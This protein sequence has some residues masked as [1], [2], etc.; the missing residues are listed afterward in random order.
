MNPKI[1]ALTTATEQSQKDY[2]QLQTSISSLSDEKVGKD[3]FDLEV[4]KL[5]KNYQ[6]RVAQEIT[7]INQKLDAIQNKIDD[8]QKNYRS[9]K[10][11]MKSLSKKASPVESTGTN[12]AAIPSKS[13]SI[14]EQDLQ[15]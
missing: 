15:E 12:E 14:N 5:R 3:T 11:S 10:R 2:S 9:Q 6:N 7:S 13:G 8:I 4:F 1:T